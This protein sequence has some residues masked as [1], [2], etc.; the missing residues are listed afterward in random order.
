MSGRRLWR[1]VSKHSL[2]LLAVSRR[3]PDRSLPLSRCLIE[4]RQDDRQLRNAALWNEFI[5]RQRAAVFACGQMKVWFTLIKTSI[6]SAFKMD[7]Y[8]QQKAPWLSSV[9]PMTPAQGWRWT[10]T[11][12]R[13]GLSSVKK[14]IHLR[15]TQKVNSEVSLKWEIV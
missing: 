6:Y 5:E 12:R 13:S 8:F 15:K 4:E 3:G 10:A 1:L 11:R 9:D 7:W 14:P 2:W